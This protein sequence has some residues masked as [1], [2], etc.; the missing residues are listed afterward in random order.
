[1]GVSTVNISDPASGTS[2]DF[3]AS[4]GVPFVYGIELRPAD[5]PDNLGFL[6]PPTAIEP[7]AQDMIAALVEIAGYATRVAAA[8]RDQIETQ[9]RDANDVD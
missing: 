6:A 1:M 4:L 8:A 2:I 3:V 5:T 7:T 9:N